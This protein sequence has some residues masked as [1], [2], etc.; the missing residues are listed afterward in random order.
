MYS[1]LTS[2]K[3]FLFLCFFLL[4][5]DFLSAQINLCEGFYV[6]LNGDTVKGK[7]D[8]LNWIITPDKINFTTSGLEKDIIP[9]LP[10]ELKSF[11]FFRKE[12]SEL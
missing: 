3:T 2:I 5:L 10:K 7:V 8:Y 6:N 12:R 1:K 11:K 4:N 9:L